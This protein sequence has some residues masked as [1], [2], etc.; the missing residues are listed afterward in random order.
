M[1]EITGD[2]NSET[3]NGTAEDDEI[4]SRDG[5]DTVHGNEGNDW[6]NAFYNAEGEALYYVYVGT[7]IA[8]G[9]LGND[10]I[11]GKEG[12]DQLYGGAGNDRI[13]GWA[14][15]DLV[16]GGNG[17]DDLFGADGNDTIYGRRGNDRLNSGDGTD[18]ANGGQGDDWINARYNEEG[19]VQFFVYS[20]SLTAYGGDG[21]DLLGG[22]KGEDQLYGGA[23]ND[24]IYG[25][26]G[27]DY[28]DGGP[29]NDE[30]NGGDGDDTYHIRSLN[31]H[32]WD[33]SGNDT[34]IV[35]V[36]FAKIPSFIENVQYVVDAA[37]L[38][39]WIDALLPDSSNGSYYQI[40]LGE[41]KTFWYVFPAVPPSYVDREMDSSGYRQL[42]ATQQR[43]AV[44]VLKYLE[45]F[46]DVKVGETDNPDQPNTFA[47]AINQQETTNGYAWLPGTDSLNSDILLND[48]SFNSTLGHGSHG[49]Y[50]F[51][52]E[53]GHALGLKHP[54]DEPNAYGDID[55][56]P[57]LQ[58]SEDHTRWT[59]MSISETSDEYKLTFSELD[60]AALQYLYGPSKK[61]RAG[62]DTHVYKTGTANFIWDG[63][64][65]DTIDASASYWAVVIYLEPGYQGFNSLFGKSEQITSAGQITVNFGTEIENLIGS[66]RA[67]FLVGNWLD[68]EILGN[69][70]SDRIFGQQ[71]EDTLV[72]G[73]GD[74][75]L[76]G[77]TGNDVLDGGAGDDLLD[78]G[79]GNDRLHGG[80]GADTLTGGEGIDLAVFNEYRSD[81]TILVT[82]D[83][84]IVIAVENPNNESAVASERDS[85]SGVERMEFID[86]NLA[87]DLGGNAGTVL[88]VLA[89]FRGSDGVNDPGLVGFYLNHFDNGTAYEDL[90]Q[91]AIDTFIGADADGTAMVDH[92][93]T[94][95]TGM[96]TPEDLKVYW[97]ALVDKGELSPVD[98][99]AIVADHELNLANIDFVGLSSTGV[100]YLTV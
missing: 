45:D 48:S 96:E 86:V 74:D 94:T 4:R 19:E 71:G 13:Y 83:Q 55:P 6:I 40:L 87:F 53:L 79:A 97:G 22:K 26:A 14:G 65:E 91:Q 27:N 37:P 64:G 46:I 29:G 88:K 35:S 58:G 63:G 21:D 10:L 72:G 68:N 81:A 73:A 7:L 59:M 47:I 56:P 98:L 75:E 8:Y 28:I 43:N 32:V 33:T 54:F 49:A 24:R 70:G 15:D 52:H 39:Y 92:Y 66:A 5:D 20:G 80:G 23:G 18:I 95:L 90:L 25:W 44:T 60:I 84:I 38:P 9:G 69:D 61:S 62:D 17:N 30:L 50:T 93:Y 42:T 51:V 12:E 76:S 36:S 78:G 11:G 85:L 67:D 77:W 16:D 89:A 31:D 100:E 34:A 41:G 99:A 3:L 2:D 57:Y 1:A 82:E